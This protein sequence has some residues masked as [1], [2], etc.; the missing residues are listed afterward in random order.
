MSKHITEAMAA[1]RLR[2][3]VAA[4][5]KRL[6]EAGGK[7]GGDFPHLE[8]AMQEAADCLEYIETRLEAE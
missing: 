4:C 8:G 1:A 2:R 5:R 7:Y 6:F 3:T